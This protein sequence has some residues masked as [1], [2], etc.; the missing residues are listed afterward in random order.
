ML[1]LSG[2]NM[3]STSSTFPREGYRTVLGEGDPWNFASLDKVQCV[4]SWNI[5]ISP[6]TYVYC[7]IIRFN[8]EWVL[9]SM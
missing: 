7:I 4:N 5:M 3:R 6:R 8:R 2:L 1:T 9:W